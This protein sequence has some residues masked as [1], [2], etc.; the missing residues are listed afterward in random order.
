VILLYDGDSAGEKASRRAIPLLL[1]GGLFP[2]VA[3][4]PSGEDPDTFARKSSPEELR[5]FLGAAKDAVEHLIEEAAQK[6]RGDIPARARA[7]EEIAQVIACVKDEV[8]KDLYQKRLVERMGVSGQLLAKTIRAGRP[9][10]AREVPARLSPLAPGVQREPGE[11]QEEVVQ[12][13]LPKDEVLLAGLLFVHPNL[14][15]KAKALGISRFCSHA[16]LKDVLILLESASPEEKDTNLL[17]S[18]LDDGI[19]QA[20]LG[21]LARPAELENEPHKAEERLINTGNYLY[22]KAKDRKIAELVS[23]IKLA[24]AEGDI[25]RE[26]Q[27]L[28]ELVRV[29]K[30]P[31]DLPRRP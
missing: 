6:T 2:K 26:S 31:Q 19:K 9:E 8:A 16:G 23:A 24:Q 3:A 28:N 12:E 11:D 27:L 18:V 4:L 7:A 15:P 29:R 5:S 30:A 20:L 22:K 14:R 17:A 13:P 25:D 1:E 10:G 21:V